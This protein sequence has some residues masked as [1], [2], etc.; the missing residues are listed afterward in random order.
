MVFWQ[1]IVDFIKGWAYI[2]D[3]KKIF[4]SVSDT[5]GRLGVPLVKDPIKNNTIVGYQKSTNRN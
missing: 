1:V 3:D 5:H 4:M 2:W